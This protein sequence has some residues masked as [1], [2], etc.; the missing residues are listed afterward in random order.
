M[1][2]DL[3]IPQDTLSEILLPLARHFLLPLEAAPLLKLRRQVL[4]AKTRREAAAMAASAAAAKGLELSPRGLER[5]AAA[6]DPGIPGDAPG[7]REEPGEGENGEN[8]ENPGGSEYPRGQDLEKKA[9]M[10]DREDPL[11]SILNRVPGRDGRFMTV[12]PFTFS[13]NG[14]VYRVSV[15]VLL[16]AGPAA[17]LPPEQSV[18]RMSVDIA[19]GSRRWVFS[20]DK[21]GRTGAET[22]V[23]TDPPLGRTSFRALSAGLEAALGD[24]GGRIVSAESPDLPL[25]PPGGAKNPAQTPAGP[26]FS[27]NEEV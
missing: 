12:F 26:L 27:V 17:A 9:A 2:L 14:R 24:W 8:R 6:M 5:Y 13:A 11:L 22:R 15:R 4:S 1:A 18:D 10:L 19:G 20:L 25:F 16:N 7:E 3:G 21:P 23:Y